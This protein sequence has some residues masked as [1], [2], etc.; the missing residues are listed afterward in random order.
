MIIR[1]EELR[2]WAAILDEDGEGFSLV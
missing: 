1:E 2:E